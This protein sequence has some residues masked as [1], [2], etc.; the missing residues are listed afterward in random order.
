MASSDHT[1]PSTA[2]NGQLINLPTE[3]YAL[4]ASH[5]TNKDLKSLRLTCKRFGN[6][7]HLRIDRVFL[8]A[9]PLDVAVCRAIADHELY[10]TRVVELIWDDARLDSPPEPPRA[11]QCQHR[12]QHIEP[13]WKEWYSET[14]HRNRK[15]AKN[16]KSDDVDR[17]DHDARARW[18]A[19]QPPLDELWVHYKELFHQQQQTLKASS[20]AWALQH[21]L[22]SFP[23]LRTITLTPAAHGVPFTPLY[24]TP[25]IRALPYGFNYPIPRGWPTKEPHDWLRLSL[26]KKGLDQDEIDK[27]KWRGFRIITW[28]LARHDHAVSEF[29]V[30]V[31]LLG[32][33]LNA[34]MFDEKCDEYNDLVT[35]LLKPGFRRIDLALMVEGQDHTGWPAFRNG[36]LKTALGLASDLERVSLRT[37][38]PYEVS[39]ED[40]QADGGNEHFIPLRTI[41]PIEKWMKLRHFGLSGFIVRQNDIISLLAAL[42]S[43]LRS[44]E[45]S[46]LHFQLG[47]GTNRE[48]LFALRDNLPWRERPVAE[49]PRITMGWHEENGEPAEGQATW[50]DDEVDAFVYGSG[51]NPFPEEMPHWV[52]YGSGTVRDIFEPAN[53]RPHVDIVDLMRLG[54]IKKHPMVLPP[55]DPAWLTSE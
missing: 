45:L 44:V 18:I 33:G 6:S 12:R 5:L 27:N 10:R 53:G 11:Y 42:P 32:T 37:D 34:H 22:S 50:V 23:S 16:R 21:A 46:F 36:N 9:S 17:P 19:A 26:W 41:F 29:V 14:C 13:F 31:S 28:M 55:D 24:Q 48:F 1:P 20:D 47:H 2:K 4:I 39:C 30:D 25:M 15:D 38:V 43:T 40:W 52:S 35:M 54:I 7:V 51:D 8:S 49:R 3:L